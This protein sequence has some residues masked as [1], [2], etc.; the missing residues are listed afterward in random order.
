MARK[1]AYVVPYRRKREGK[2]DY[3]GRMN[4]LKSE[5]T[6]LVVRP[7]NKHMTV[8]L[9][10]YRKEGDLVVSMAH[11]KELAEFG[12][13]YSTSNLP[14]AYLTGMLCG[15]RGA[16]KGVKTAI[17][18]IGLFPSIAGS[19][20][21]AA[22]KGAIDAGLKIPADAVIFPNEKRVTG[23]HIVQ[24]GKKETLTEEF[25]KVKEKIL[26]NGKK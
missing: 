16:K 12:W 13:N 17:L 4:L 10:D 19:K 8:Q 3:K 20:T 14:A 9:V 21:Y 26:E 2:T 11:S 15:L 1:A 23:E 24:K 7:S 22:L 5:T 18:D 25:A 6:R